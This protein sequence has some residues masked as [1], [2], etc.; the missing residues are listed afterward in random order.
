MGADAAKKTSLTDT[1]I[2]LTSPDGLAMPLGGYRVCIVPGALE[3]S[4]RLGSLE[5]IRDL[6]RVLRATISGLEDTTDGEIDAPITLAKHGVK[7][8]AAKLPSPDERTR[9]YEPATP[10]PRARR[11]GFFSIRGIANDE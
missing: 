5:E 10:K 8:A 2:P 1:S 4:A 6:I 9:H 11:A 3:V 7:D